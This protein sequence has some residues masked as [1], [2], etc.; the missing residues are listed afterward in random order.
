[1]DVTSRLSRSTGWVK[2]ISAANPWIK[3]MGSRHSFHYKISSTHK[4]HKRSFVR[5]VLQPPVFFPWGR[6]F[7]T[8]VCIL[9]TFLAFVPDKFA[10]IGN[11]FSNVFASNTFALSKTDLSSKY[12][13]D[14]KI[15]AANKMCRTRTVS[16]ADA[17]WEYPC[18]QLED[19]LVQI[20]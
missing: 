12:E 20:F 6:H 17:V 8:F 15:T 13:G 10:D 7:T 16:S 3:S 5:G 14:M 9:A 4:T 1:M 2:T 18:W 11:R 19:F